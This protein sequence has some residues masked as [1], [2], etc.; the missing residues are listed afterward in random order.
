MNYEQDSEAILETIDGAA[1]AR[2]DPRVYLRGV[3][4]K[5]DTQRGYSRQVR[6]L[7]WNR[8]RN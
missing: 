6:Y 7:T 5:K 3:R 2:H 8:A 1:L 4:S